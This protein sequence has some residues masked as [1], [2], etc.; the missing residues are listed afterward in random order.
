MNRLSRDDV[1]VRAKLAEQAER[2]RDMSQAMKALAEMGTDLTNDE[3]NMFSFGYKN[4]VGKLRSSWRVVSSMEQQ[5]EEEEPWKFEKIQIY[6]EKIQ[7]E[8]EATCLEVSQLIDNHLMRLASNDEA[9]VFYLKMKGDYF[10]YQAEVVGDPDRRRKIVSTADRSYKEAIEVAESSLRPVNPIRL[11]LVL[12]Y[13]VFLYEV[14]AANKRAIK[15]AKEAFEEALQ[16][17]DAFRDDAYKDSTIVMQL[18]RDNVSMWSSSDGPPID[19]L[20]D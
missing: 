17:L 15:L 2:F 9:K 6:R 10:R 20:P 3:R 19:L 8:I 4:V 12:N 11:G 18:I 7:A 16:E 13:S 14:K 5:C 1:L